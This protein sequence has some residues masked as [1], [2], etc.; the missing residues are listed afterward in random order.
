MSVVSMPE[1]KR[2]IIGKKP[3]G[4][5]LETRVSALEHRMSAVEI[6]A[7]EAA[8]NSRELLAI[9]NAARGVGG[10]LKKHGPR[11]IAFGT[12]AAAT[13]G[14]GNPAL[15]KFIATFFAA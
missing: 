5:S 1:T 4:P 8:D 9:A 6:A 2:R 7:Q 14:M 11:I 10:F 3:S 13:L 15:L 12:G